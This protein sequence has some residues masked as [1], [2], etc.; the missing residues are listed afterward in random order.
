MPVFLQVAWPWSP[1]AGA[2]WRGFCTWQES[3]MGNKTSISLCQEFATGAVVWIPNLN[4]ARGKP[5]PGVGRT[6]FCACLP[7]R[8]ES[9]PEEG[10]G[11]GVDTGNT[12]LA[13][14]SRASSVNNISPQSHA[15]CQPAQVLCHG[16]CLLGAE[17]FRKSVTDQCAPTLK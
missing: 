12:L 4:K 5:D 16:L 9:Q 13:P 14:V 6:S 8:A 2:C 1:A 17:V 11:G 7:W 10:A 3:L 15:E